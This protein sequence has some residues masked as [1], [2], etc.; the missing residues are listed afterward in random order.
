[1]GL[2]LL[3]RTPLASTGQCTHPLRIVVP[4][5]SDLGIPTKIGR[6]FASMP[7]VKAG[8]RNPKRNVRLEARRAREHIPLMVGMPLKPLEPPWGGS[9]GNFL[10]M[11]RRGRQFRSNSRSHPRPFRP[12]QSSRPRIAGAKGTCVGFQSMPGTRSAGLT[13]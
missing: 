3:L 11:V 10:N 7:R 9:L 8:G 6:E 4:D 13:P 1:M 5:S 12:S 2:Y